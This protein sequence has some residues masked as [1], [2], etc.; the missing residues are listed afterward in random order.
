MLQFDDGNG[1]RSCVC[2]FWLISQERVTDWAGLRGCAVL[3]ELVE[4]RLAQPDRGQLL[5]ADHAGNAPCL[6]KAVHLL[7]RVGCPLCLSIYR[8]T[9]KRSLLRRLV[10]A[11]ARRCLW[12][13]QQAWRASPGYLLAILDPISVLLRWLQA[14]AQ[15]RECCA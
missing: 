1:L 6:R 3:H 13:R 8:W 2:V 12:W 14:I 4:V 9:Y 5:R 15:P 11:R 10:G 7:C